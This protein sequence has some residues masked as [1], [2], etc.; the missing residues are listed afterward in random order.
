MRVRILAAVSAALLAT[1]LAPAAAFAGPVNP[2]PLKGTVWTTMAG[3]PA[4]RAPA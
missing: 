4:R 3:R 2:V 1:A